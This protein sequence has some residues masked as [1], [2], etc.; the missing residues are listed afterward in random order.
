M[1]GK[2]DACGILMRYRDMDVDGKGTCN[3]SRLD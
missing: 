2:I 1:T 3:C